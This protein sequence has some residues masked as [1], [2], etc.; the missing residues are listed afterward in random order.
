MLNVPKFSHDGSREAVEWVNK[1]LQIYVNAL[2][3]VANC[4]RRGIYTAG[5]YAYYS[6]FARLLPQQA[7]DNAL[8]VEF[9]FVKGYCS[10]AANRQTVPAQWVH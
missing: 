5:F 10:S 7:T 1:T 3:S 9:T 4:P 8:A 6:V 2:K